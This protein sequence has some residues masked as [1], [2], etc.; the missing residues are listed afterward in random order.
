MESEGRGFGQILV[1]FFVRAILGM[2]LIFFVNELLESQGSSVR[3]GM[4][5]L[6]L[7]T[8]GIFGIPGVALLYGIC[9]FKIL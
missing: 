2:A 7:L 1:N 8:F 6:T 3:V 9:F 5:V 4:N